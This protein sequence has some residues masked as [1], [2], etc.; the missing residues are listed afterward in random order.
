MKK[1]IKLG[2]MSIS[3][4]NI[5]KNIIGNFKLINHDKY[6]QNSD[7]CYL[8]KNEECKGRKVI[9]NNDYLMIYPYKIKIDRCIGSCN[10][11]NNPYFKVRLPDTVK[12]ISV[13]FFNLLT[14]K[15]V[16]RNISFHQSCKC[17]CLLDEKICNNLLKW[18]KDKCRCE[19]LEIKTVKLVILGMSI[20]VNVK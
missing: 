20:I 18:N 17:K 4:C 5:I 12:N 11:K 6:L 9:V 3:G 1:V 13:K 14:Q 7:R 2:L 16:L 15:N 8:V 10:S 19:C